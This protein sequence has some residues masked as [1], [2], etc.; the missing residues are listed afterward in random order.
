MSLWKKESADKQESKFKSG[1]F[2]ISIKNVSNVD[3]DGAGIGSNSFRNVS[4]II[5]DILLD[6]S[7]II[8]DFIWLREEEKRRSGSSLKQNL[9][10]VGI[11]C[12]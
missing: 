3:A 12:C 1:A 2:N 8:T 5:N 4:K 10:C 6:A 11:V 9:R 7:F